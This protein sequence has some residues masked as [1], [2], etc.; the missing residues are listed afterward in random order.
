MAAKPKKSSNN[1]DR[2]NKN[3]EV[4]QPDI[5]PSL[6]ADI[7][8]I[9]ERLSQLE[10]E[11]DNQAIAKASK[12]NLPVTKGQKPKKKSGFFNKFL[13]T[14][15]LI[16]L[17]VGFV[18]IANLPYP[19]IRQ[20]VARSMPLILIP[21]FISMDHNYRQAIKNVEQADQLINQATAKTDIELGVSK[22]Q[23]AQQNLDQLP[24]W[25]LGAYPQRYC[26]LFGCSWRFTLDEFETARK[27]VA[28]MEAKAFQEKN[29]LTQLEQAEQ[30]I[31]TGKQQFQQGKS[32]GEKQASIATWQTGINQLQQ[33]PQ[34]TLAGRSIKIDQAIT[35]FEQT[36]GEM[37]ETMG[38]NTLISSAKIY[39]MK[40]AQLA[41]NA[42]HSLE[43]WQ[44]IEAGWQTAIRELEQ[45]PKTNSEYLAAQKLLAQYQAN[46]GDIRTRMAMEET[47]MRA[48][49]Q[50]KNLIPNLQR[51][52]TNSQDNLGAIG[53]QMQ[54]IINYLEQV[55]PGTTA[56]NEAQK[57]LKQAKEKM[58]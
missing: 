37:A 2:P 17:P 55:K 23:L 31:N 22:V 15:L 45:I 39:G 30:T 41:Q 46:L 4:N 27:D 21:S 57:W 49:Q 25:F 51:M 47:S 7:V 8:P 19:V 32:L 9:N 10:K 34:A 16:G 20:P 14:A 13:G 28:R 43:K 52:A 54:E 56:Y 58:K 33:V 1:S 50:A 5:L 40:A 44:T 38:G 29:A 3:A 6:K 35:E 48:L 53:G 18:A 26:S 11:L 12:Q 42:P 36:T 24:I